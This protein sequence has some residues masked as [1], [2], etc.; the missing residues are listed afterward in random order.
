MIPMRGKIQKPYRC[1]VQG[2]GASQMDGDHKHVCEL[3][4]EKKSLT[5]SQEKQIWRRMDTL[6]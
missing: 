1:P 6:D 3:V 2:H 4:A 5:R